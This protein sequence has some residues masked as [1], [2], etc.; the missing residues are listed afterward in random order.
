MKKSVLLLLA[1]S[2]LS[3]C[4]TS[5]LHNTM[6]ER[7]VIFHCNNAET[8]HVRFNAE[9]E[10]ATLVRNGAEVELAQQP[11]GS[12]FLYSNGPNTIRGQADKLTVEIG[13]MM[14]FECVAK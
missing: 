11:T 2:L 9:K 6:P 10:L 4:S 5:V 7:E 8:L 1:V 3:A 14:P 13:R 12:G